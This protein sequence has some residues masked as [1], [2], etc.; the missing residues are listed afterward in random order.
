MSF[1]IKYCT[2]P[3]HLCELPCVPW[4]NLQ[5]CLSIRPF[6]IL[7]V[8]PVTCKS[9]SMILKILFMW[10]LLYP[11]INYP[12]NNSSF[13][14][15]VYLLPKPKSCPPLT[16]LLSSILL[17]NPWTCPPLLLYGIP[18]PSL[19]PTLLVYGILQPSLSQYLLFIM[20]SNPGTCP[21]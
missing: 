16:V 8:P 17:S 15:I 3:C 7:V 12:F 21:L 20:L 13:Y 4:S 10:P 6:D 9:N 1:L 5:I 19:S 11:I 2:F 18:Q 14:L